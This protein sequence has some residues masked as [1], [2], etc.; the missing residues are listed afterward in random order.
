MDNGLDSRLLV[1][2]VLQGDW[3]HSLETP[4]WEATKPQPSLLLRY[5]ASQGRPKHPIRFSES[6]CSFLVLE[7]RRG[8]GV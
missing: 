7:G 3:L 5:L 6:W 2:S 4:L 8:L 1:K